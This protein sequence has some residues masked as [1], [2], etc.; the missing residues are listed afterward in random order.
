VR[1]NELI[2]DLIAFSK[3]TEDPFV[4]VDATELTTVEYDGTTNTIIFNKVVEPP[5]GDDE[6]EVEEEE[7]EEEEVEEEPEAKKSPVLSKK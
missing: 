3:H 2:R 1:M 4:F 5:P 6:P 7:V